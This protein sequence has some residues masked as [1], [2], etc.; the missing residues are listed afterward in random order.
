VPDPTL[1]TYLIICEERCTRTLK[2]F[3]SIADKV[4]RVPLALMSDD[5]F[6]L[7]SFHFS[8][9][10]WSFYSVKQIDCCDPRVIVMNLKCMHESGSTK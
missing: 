7:F 6:E 1:Q 5:D 4:K 8:P 9:G 3:F 10:E 2:G